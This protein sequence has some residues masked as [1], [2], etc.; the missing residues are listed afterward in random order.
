MGLVARAGLVVADRWFQ[1]ERVDD[2][3]TVLTEPFVHP[4]LR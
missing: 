3:V 2:A 1:R 4:L